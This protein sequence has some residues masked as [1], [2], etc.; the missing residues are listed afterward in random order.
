VW[1]GYCGNHLWCFGYWRIWCGIQLYRQPSA[2]KTDYTFVLA[3]GTAGD[4]DYTTTTVTVTVPA[5]ATTGTVS[6]PTTQDNDWWKWN[7][8]AIAWNSF[9]LLEQS[10]CDNEP[11]VETIADASATEGSDV[12]STLPWAT[13]LQ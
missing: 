9:A 3:N 7:F 10:W 4:L 1:Y 12:Y 5:G 8:I 6:V 13:L 2:V 11:T